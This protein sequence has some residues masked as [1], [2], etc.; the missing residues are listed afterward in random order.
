MFCKYYVHEKSLR[1]KTQK[2][3]MVFF[4]FCTSSITIKT[5][6]DQRKTTQKTASKDSCC[7]FVYRHQCRDSVRN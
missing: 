6:Q 3:I 2:S 1:V 7:M 4:I 5:S